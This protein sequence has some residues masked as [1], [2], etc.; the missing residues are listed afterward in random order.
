MREN[1]RSTEMPDKNSMKPDMP[2]PMSS[3]FDIRAEEYNEHMLT[4][5]GE[6]IYIKL[7]RYIPKT[8]EPLKILD[9]G[10]G[11]GLELDY[12]WRQA[13]NAHITCLDISQK[14]LELLLATHTGKH[15]QT[16]VIRASYLDWDYLWEA[17]DMAVSSYTMHHLLPDEKKKAYRK[18]KG[19][20]KPGGSYIESDF[21]VDNAM[22]EQYMQEYDRIVRSM[23][24]RP[25]AGEYHIDIPFTADTQLE[26]LL[27]AGFKSACIL[28]QDIKL[29]G[30]RAVFKAVK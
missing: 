11:T 4:D 9:I 10:C 8:E 17:F 14:M 12:I 19:S 22:A 3:F 7:G 29:R 5:I 1:V 20:L 15:D 30:S 21:T 2:E 18:I 27:E 25:K 16:E 6:E 13:P 26:L 24:R 28:E 23:S